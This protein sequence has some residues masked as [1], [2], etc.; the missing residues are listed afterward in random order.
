MNART[1]LL[2]ALLLSPCTVAAQDT[3]PTAWGRGFHATGSA[4]PDGAAA[5]LGAWSPLRPIV[6]APRGLLRAPLAPGLFEAPSPVAGAFVLA[7]APGAL[8][9]DFIRGGDTMTFG[10]LRVRRG[11]ESGN[12]RRPLDVEHSLV[13]QVWGQGYSRV[14]SRGMAIGRF[15]VDQEEN[16]PGSFTSRI[17]PYVAY[18]VV[19]TDTLEPPM[20]RTRARLEGALAW[21]VGEFGVGVAAALESREHNSVNVP[22]RR[23]GRAATPAVN[24]GVERTLPWFE[25]RVGG[26][27]RW[28]E[29]NETNQVRP[30]PG[31]ATVYP[32]RGLDEPFG[33]P[34]SPNHFPRNERR[35][36]ATGV[37]LSALMFG[38][39][40]VVAYEQ[41]NRAEDESVT[42]FSENRV[43]VERWRA[44]G[45]EL[46]ALVQRPVTSW[47]TATAVTSI[48]SSDGEGRRAE[49]D[50]V[51]FEGVW[52]KR[53]IEVDLRTGSWR[54]WSAALLGGMVQTEHSLEDYVAQ[55]AASATVS[56]P[57]IGLEVGRRVFGGSL[58][59]GVSMAQQS[60]AS[61]RLPAVADRG[62]Q[63][64]ILIAPAWSYEVSE[65]RALAM[66]VNATLPV[67][68][69]VLVASVRRE[70]T[71]PQSVVTSRLQPGG[72][73]SSWSLSLG[74]RP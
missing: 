5:W 73:R 32:L 48:E 63:Y 45:S 59:A 62:E 26:Y 69:S 31:T 30:N 65:A 70:Q 53:A 7:G 28:S 35:T 10:E 17:Q 16:N 2:T 55:L 68:R 36:T 15:I 38:A 37:S 52:S 46:R 61:A 24:V 58:S 1:A 56:V 27:F 22:V 50:G 67:R 23:S 39:D 57:F 33:I 25:A 4:S 12:F 8:A 11:T 42:P 19:R 18:P 60:P 20:Q 44:S 34:A 21:R 14:G 43:D 54:E 49:F 29:A 41:G 3:P 40:V 72:E 9:R 13:S 64:R 51:A 47:L 66:W 6:D 71:S 74:I